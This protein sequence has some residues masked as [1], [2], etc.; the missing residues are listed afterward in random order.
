MIKK[1]LI[2]AIFIL[3][4]SCGFQPMLKEM[5]NTNIKIKKID[6]IGENEINYQIKNT[7]GLVE[8]PNSNGLLI[9]LSTKENTTVVNK[10]NSGVTT[11][12]KLTISVNLTITDNDKNNLLT[13]Q[14]SES[15]RFQLSSNSVDDESEKNNILGNLINIVSQKIKFK[16]L[17]LSKNLK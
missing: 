2:Y 8:E 16:L 9:T 15:A 10:N 12:E 3:I 4:V 11:E 13:E 1:I 17:I 5:D 14:I 7:L 6:F